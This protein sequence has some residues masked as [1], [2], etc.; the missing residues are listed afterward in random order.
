MNQETIKS[1]SIPSPHFLIKDHK[2]P[3][4]VG[5]FPTRLVIPAT[6]FTALYSKLGYLGVKR[7]LDDRGVDCMK[8][9]IIQACDLKEHFEEC[10]IEKREVAVVSIDAVN[11]YPLVKIILIK[12]AVQYCT[13][14]LQRPA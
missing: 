9:T 1:Q 10:N 7:I 13:R 3:D 11:M 4:D 2:D 6:N 5:N 8:S 14:H 12:K